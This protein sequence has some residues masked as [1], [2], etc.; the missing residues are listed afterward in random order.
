MHDEM[1]GLFEAMSAIEM[2]DPKMDAGMMCNRINRKVL[3]L[4]DSIAAGLKVKDMSK[5]E[6]IGIM[7]DTMCC[8]MSW[9]DGHTLA[10][11][12]FTNLYLHDPDLIEDKCLK[13]FSLLILA[14][15]DVMRLF[16]MK[17]EVFEEEDFQYALYNYKL[18]FSY[19]ETK[20]CSLIRELEDEMGKR[21]KSLIK[22]CTSNPSSSP[23]TTTTASSANS[24]TNHHHHHHHN[25]LVFTDALIEK[26]YHQV[27][28]I[29]CRMRLLRSLLMS[30]IMILRET[31][32]TPAKDQGSSAAAAAAGSKVIQSNPNLVQDASK[33]LQV[34]QDSIPGWRESIVFGITAGPRSSSN[35]SSSTCEPR[36]DYPTIMGF[37]PLI[38][39]RLLP[40]TF[41]RYTRLR[42]RQDSLNELEILIRRLM[43][44]VRVKQMPCF[45]QALDFFCDFSRFYAGTCV[46][47]RSVLQLTYVP[48]ACTP[49]SRDSFVELIKDASNRFIRPPCLQSRFISTNGSKQAI[50]AF[51]IQS[52]RPMLSLL[53][54]QGHNRARQ[55]EKLAQ[56][57]DEMTAFQSES[58]KVDAL[59]NKFTQ[60]L[61]PPVCHMGFFSTWVLYHVIRVMIQYLNSGFEL[62]LYSDHEFPYI[63]W[64][65]YE[66]LYGWLISTLTRAS[67][68]SLEQQ[69]LAGQS[70]GFLFFSFDITRLTSFDSTDLIKAKQNNKKVNKNRKKQKERPHVRQLM[71][72]QASQQLC[73][74][75]FK[76][77][78]AFRMEGRLRQPS[79]QAA[80]ISSEKL[81]YDHRFMPFFSVIAPPAITYQQFRDMCDQVRVSGH[82]EPQE[83][84]AGAFQC[85]D[86]AKRILTS[87]PDP[88]EEVIVSSIVLLCPQRLTL[89]CILQMMSCLKVAKTNQVVTKLLAS[90]IQTS[91]VSVICTCA[92]KMVT[93]DLSFTLFLDSHI[94][95]LTFR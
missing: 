39:Q 15:T 54:I 71:L 49:A 17:A 32:V 52:L 83:L 33:H 13:S 28:G 2:M 62:E 69:N 21:M 84:F 82:A 72:S 9:L 7:D 20:I 14:L 61:D 57:L 12:L 34:C 6:M 90:G 94:P 37:E 8:L 79:L 22:C 27:H 30:L 1:F 91:K 67:N 5:E 16:V 78:F 53:Q 93:S 74:G 11:T 68:F 36:A 19:S 42:N 63:Y 41:P 56:I 60:K 75:I 88:T 81:R 25:N 4:K 87:I 44:V 55:R 86:D 89:F 23:P 35:S 24:A 46:L 40:A 50:E 58:E 70:F 43:H 80:G 38:N 48:Q 73:G 31:N 10:Q 64:Y 66:Y 59:L 51:F 47:S 92:A 29:L 95:N 18:H 26:E 77:V 85:F 76:T 3:N 65:L 45:H